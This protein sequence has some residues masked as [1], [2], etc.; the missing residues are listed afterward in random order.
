LGKLNCLYFGEKSKRASEFD[1]LL[2]QNQITNELNQEETENNKTESI[3]PLES[4]I[5]KLLL[6]NEEGI[7]QE[8]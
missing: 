3:L 5:E 2:H 8:F 4:T 6:I 1:I 7:I